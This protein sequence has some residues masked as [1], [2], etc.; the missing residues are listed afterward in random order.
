MLMTISNSSSTLFS[1]VGG[2]HGVIWRS[3]SCILFFRNLKLPSHRPSIVCENCL[4][5]LEKDK[6]VRAFHVM[7]PQGFLDMLLVFLEERTPESTPV[8]PSFDDS[9]VS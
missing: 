3:F 4:Y 7:D 8:P 6:R 2:V 1:F 9:E 5:S